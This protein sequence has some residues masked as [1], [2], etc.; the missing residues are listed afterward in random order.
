MVDFNANNNED[1]EVKLLLETPS[2]SIGAREDQLMN[3]LINMNPKGDVLLAISDIHN[4]ESTSSLHDKFKS[5]I[6]KQ[7]YVLCPGN[8]GSKRNKMWLDGLSK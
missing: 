8:I 3:F 5:L 6:L 7:N 4:L 1:Q 2:K